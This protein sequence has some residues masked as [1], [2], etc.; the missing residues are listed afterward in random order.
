M[1]TLRKRL[2]RYLVNKN[3]PEQQVKEIITI[4]I[5]TIEKALPT[6]RIK[7][8]ESENC[9]SAETYDLI[10]KRLRPILDRLE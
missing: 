10:L 4:A 7:W 2:E 5:P 6:H 8:D 1:L 3:F 9:C